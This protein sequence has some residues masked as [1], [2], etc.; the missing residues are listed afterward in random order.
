MET[1]KKVLWFNLAI[2]ALPAIYLAYVWNKLPERVPMHYDI[3]GHID[4]Y[5]DKSEMI[6]V[7]LI[8]LFSGMLTTLLVIYLPKI[9]PKRNSAVTQKI[10]KKISVAISIFMAMINIYIIF[11]TEHQSFNSPRPVL[12]AVALLFVFLGNLMNN[13]KPNYFIGIRTPWTLESEEVWRKTHHLSAKLWF[14]TGLGLALLMLVLPAIASVIVF[15]GATL[16]IAIIPIVYSYRLFKQVNG[17][18]PGN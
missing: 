18:T 17:T 15:I 8:L 14:W 16:A 5:G 3:E 12:V 10:G 6:S 2:L 9:D 4:R 7:N 13:V 1:N 11:V